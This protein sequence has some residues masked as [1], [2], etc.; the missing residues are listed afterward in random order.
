MAF[1]HERIEVWNQFIA[2]F[3]CIANERSY[4]GIHPGF[5]YAANSIVIFVGFE[6]VDC[7]AWGVDAELNP[8]KEEFRGGLGAFETAYVVTVALESQHK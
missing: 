1:E 5:D 3:D 6:A 7:E 2:T 4:F 8:T